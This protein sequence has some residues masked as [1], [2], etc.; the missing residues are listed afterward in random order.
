MAY[1]TTVYVYIL[2]DTDEYLIFKSQHSFI[3]DLKHKNKTIYL[4]NGFVYN[5]LFF[6]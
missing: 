4:E 6:F 3:F 5:F 2:L 1:E